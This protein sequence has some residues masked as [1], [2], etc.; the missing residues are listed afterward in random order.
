MFALFTRTCVQSLQASAKLGVAV[1]MRSGEF[2]LIAQSAFALAGRQRIRAEVVLATA[3]VFL[4][5]A[6]D[7]GVI[8]GDGACREEKKEK[9][10]R[11]RDEKMD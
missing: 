5:V 8:L 3:T 10:T 4:G 1:T 7:V 6:T 9:E 2:L 11:A